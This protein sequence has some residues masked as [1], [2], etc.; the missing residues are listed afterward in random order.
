MILK[1]ESWKNL[2]VLVAEDDL[3]YSMIISKYLEPTGIHIVKASN[4]KEAVELCKN[5]QFDLILM[6]IYMPVMDGFEATKEIR[7]FNKDVVIIAETEY[8]N[9]RERCLSSGFTDYIH[10]PFTQ[11]ELNKIMEKHI[12]NSSCKLKLFF[13]KFMSI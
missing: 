5:D 12:S 7:G 1:M 8:S 13:K 4:G 11:Y 2:K 10:K 9:I 6:N 3:I